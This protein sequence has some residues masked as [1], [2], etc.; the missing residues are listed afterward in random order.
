MADLGLLLLFPGRQP[1]LLR[2]SLGPEL[3]PAPPSNVSLTPPLPERSGSLGVADPSLDSIPK[4]IN[5]SPFHLPAS[6]TLCAVGS[7]AGDALVSVH[8]T[9]ST[10]PCCHGFASVSPGFWERPPP[11]APSPR[12][13]DR[14]VDLSYSSD[15]LSSGYSPHRSGPSLHTSS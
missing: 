11:T 3:S 14:L 8:S 1:H 2:L 4:G 5:R 12:S 10:V 9:V 15:S 13:S 6:Q 7:A